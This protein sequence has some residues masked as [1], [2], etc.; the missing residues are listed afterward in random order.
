MMLDLRLAKC[1]GPTFDR[2]QM[3]DG[4]IKADIDEVLRHE[5]ICE[6]DF[7]ALREMRKTLKEMLGRLRRLEGW[8]VDLD[9]RV[10]EVVKMMRRCRWEGG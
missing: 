2:V 7:E 8:N 1:N 9:G 6:E 3:I 5:R 10:G 4:V